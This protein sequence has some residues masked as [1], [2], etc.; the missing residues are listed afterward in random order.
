MTQ[1]YENF[2]ETATDQT[3]LSK[4]KFLSKT[5]S[6]ANNVIKHDT[7]RE[8]RNS[9]GIRHVTLFGPPRFTTMDSR[10]QTQTTIRNA[11]ADNVNW[12]FFRLV[13]VGLIDTEKSIITKIIFWET[14]SLEAN[15]DEGTE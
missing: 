4:T 11:I 10:L 15:T 7:D 1:N 9:L 6:E 14:G 12:Q 3:A 8:S 13:G 5:K 2:F